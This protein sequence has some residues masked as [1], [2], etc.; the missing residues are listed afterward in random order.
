MLFVNFL[1]FNILLHYCS[2]VLNTRTSSYAKHIYFY[3]LLMVLRHDLII[4]KKNM[5]TGQKHMSHGQKGM[6]NLAFIYSSK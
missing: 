5:Q 3:T 6:S 1:P 4:E 2:E